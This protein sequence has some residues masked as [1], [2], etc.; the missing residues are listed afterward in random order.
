[1]LAAV[2]ATHHPDFKETVDDDEDVR[3][4][5]PKTTGWSQSVAREVVWEVFHHPL[6]GGRTPAQVTFCVCF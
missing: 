4:M 2:R 5:S 3:E 1:M 6:L